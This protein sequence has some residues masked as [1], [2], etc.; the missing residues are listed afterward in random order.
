MGAGAVRGSCRFCR[1]SCIN[2]LRVSYEA[3]GLGAPPAE[4]MRG[5][6]LGPT[7]PLPENMAPT[8]LERPPYW[9]LGP[10]SPLVVCF[11]DVM[12]FMILNRLPNELISSSFRLF[13]FNSSKMAP[14]I[15]LSESVV[16]G[17]QGEWSRSKRMS[18][19][20]IHTSHAI[21]KQIHST[22]SLTDE[23]GYHAVESAPTQPVG[24]LVNVPGGRMP[25]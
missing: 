16:V 10:W 14:E 15:S 5:G 2:S 6:M 12:A 11:R 22:L 21:A 18:E 24:N 8:E 25:C 4:V 1:G 20:E 19:T 23:T 3:R 13:R 7:P 17:Q 9:P